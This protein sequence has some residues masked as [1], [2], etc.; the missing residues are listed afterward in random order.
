[1]ADLSLI[2]CKE[3]PATEGFVLVCIFALAASLAFSQSSNQISASG[4]LTLIESGLLGTL[5]TGLM[6]LYWFR[7]NRIKAVMGSLWG[8]KGS[9]KTIPDDN[10]VRLLIPKWSMLIF[11]LVSCLILGGFCAAFFSSG[12]NWKESMLIGAT[13]ESFVAGVVIKGEKEQESRSGA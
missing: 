4:R 10:G 3:N 1:M 2:N 11:D 9:F 7:M 8:S 6:Y 5:G 12:A 13:W